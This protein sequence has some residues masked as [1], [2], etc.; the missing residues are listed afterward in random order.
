[1]AF[2][3]AELATSD[4]DANFQ[5]GTSGSVLSR[6]AANFAAVFADQLASS[7]DIDFDAIA[8][9]EAGWLF[10]LLGMTWLHLQFGLLQMPVGCPCLFP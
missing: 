1:V 5:D 3:F 2:G 8:K 6:W 4:L 9:M 7:L 10:R